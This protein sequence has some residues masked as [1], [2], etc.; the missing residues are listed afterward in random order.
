MNMITEDS[1]N[2]IVG[3][4]LKITSDISL[5]TMKNPKGSLYE[6]HRTQIN[7]ITKAYVELSKKVLDRVVAEQLIHYLYFDF[8]KPVSEY[9]GFNMSA[10]LPSEY[11][12]IYL[13]K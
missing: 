10:R 8:E 3:A 12:M 7:G 11:M 9:L 1:A 2:E 13:K 5:E 4:I 6:P